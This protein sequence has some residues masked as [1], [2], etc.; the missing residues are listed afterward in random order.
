MDDYAE[1]PPAC[2]YPPPP[3]ELALIAA[4]DDEASHAVIAHLHACPHC[5]AR[6]QQLRV[7][8]EILRRKLYRAFCVSTHD[9]L[10]YQH[11]LVGGARRAQIAAHLAECPHCAA[12]LVLLSEAARA[13]SGSGLLTHVRRIIAELLPPRAPQLLAPLYGSARSLGETQYAYRAEHVELTLRIG[14]AVGN[15]GMLVLSGVLAID[16]PFQEDTL[17]GATASLLCGEQVIAAA[18]LDEI[19][20]FVIHDLAPGSYALALRLAAYEVVVESLIL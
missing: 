11:L 8:N 2:C 14:R 1:E 20:S 18:P 17:G 3:D 10:A 12:E 6:A 13:E 15:P 7:I 16:D 5:A 4:L 9:L 19:G